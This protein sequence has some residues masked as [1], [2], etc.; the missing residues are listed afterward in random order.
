MPLSHRNIRPCAVCG[1]FYPGNSSDLAHLVA[2]L[3][4]RV[5][6]S[7]PGRRVQGI[8]VP[9]AG[10]LYS[11]LTA[12]HAFS[13]LRQAEYDAVVIVSPSHREFFR[14][15]ALFE[16]EGYAT[17]L[18]VLRVAVEW[19]DRLLELCPGASLSRQGHGAEHAIEVQLPF[20]Q[21]VMTDPAIIPVVMGDQS[22][23]LCMNLGRALSSL[24]TRAR[25]LLV[26]STDLSHYHSLAAAHTLDDIMINDVRQCDSV[27]LMDHLESGATEACGGG[28]T[29]AVL[30]ALRSHGV[31]SVDIL[32][33]TTSADAS[34][35]TGN[36][37]G[38]LAAAAY[39]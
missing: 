39:A 10:Y 8:V 29:V 26:A 22:R 14:G 1:K 7:A 5:G 21:H 17:P 24:M 9:H 16:G 20:L 37:V 6:S 25:I 23:A 11:G 28:P 33:H 3:L 18:G 13:L 38:Y 30:S 31:A 27:A 19:R 36:V 2:A 12:A 35:D 34:G 4:D 15:I 32:H